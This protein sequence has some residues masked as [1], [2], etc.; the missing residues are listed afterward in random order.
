[1]SH[2][3]THDIPQYHPPQLWVR[4]HRSAAT[5]TPPKPSHPPF[6]IPPKDQQLWC[7]ATSYAHTQSRPWFRSKL[8]GKQRQLVPLR[9]EGC[10]VRPARSSANFTRVGCSPQPLLLVTPPAEQQRK[11]AAFLQSYGLAEISSFGF[12]AFSFFFFFVL[13]FCFVCFFPLA[14]RSLLPKLGKKLQ[15]S[16]RAKQI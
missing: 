16:K 1:M 2:S 8:R 3:P 7:S 15:R 12:C 14:A 6:L 4:A 11:H 13:L 5:P 10:G 9:E